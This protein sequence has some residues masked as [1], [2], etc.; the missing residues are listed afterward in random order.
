[1][2]KLES[3]VES[4]NI[5][6]SN[7]KDKLYFSND[8]ED[9]NRIV[10]GNYPN[11]IMV[12]VDTLDSIAENREI[13]LLKIDVEGYEKFVF[14][15]GKETLK[16]ENLKALIVELNNSGR[17]YNV[18]DEEIYKTLLSYNFLPYEYVPLKKELLPLESYNKKQFNT[19]SV[20]YTH[21]DVYKRQSN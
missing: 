19:I 20:S 18:T 15:G 13:K 1:M 17:R 6:L 9:M 10:D 14:E 7:E 8:N 2:N 12:P 11:S 16:N 21:L 4:H 3:L 5:G